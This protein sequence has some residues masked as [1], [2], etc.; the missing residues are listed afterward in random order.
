[1]IVTHNPLE[2]YTRKPSQGGY[3]VEDEEGHPLIFPV[4][5]FDVG[6]LD[7]TNP[8][9]RQWMKSVIQDELINKAGC[10][11][12]MVDFAEAFPF[13]ATLYS[14]EDPEQHH[15]QYP[16]EWIKLNKEAVEEI[17]LLDDILLFNR[18]GFS[19]TPQHAMMIWQGDQL[20]TW[21][22]YDG[23][24][25][26]VHGLLN[27]GLSG[28]ALNHSD[29]GGYTSFVPLGF[30]L[31]TPPELLLRWTELSAFT[32]LMRT[33]EGN[34]PGSNAQVYD[35][36][37]RE[38]FAR[39][40]KIY[41]ALKPIRLALFEAATLRGHPVVRHMMLHHPTDPIAKNVHDQFCWGHQC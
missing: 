32:S 7:L 20:T 2:I 38:H 41:R 8:N 25:S 30:G 40:T 18:A 6:L 34:Q 35:E 31:H 15:N 39:M 28:I 36:E 3:F 27:G 12:W 33:H 37:V 10:S 9:G 1:M 24:L 11:G 19:T 26:A 4:T 13:E 5:A 23:L 17:G 29:I 22:R 14:E 16:V 21:D